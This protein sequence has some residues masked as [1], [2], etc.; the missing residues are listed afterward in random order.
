MHDPSTDVTASTLVASGVV[1][2]PSRAPKPVA[3]EGRRVKADGPV[4]DLVG[5]LRR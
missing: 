2:L 1:E 3:R 4:A 5:E